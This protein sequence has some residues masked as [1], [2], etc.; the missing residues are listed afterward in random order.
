MSSLNR[1][2]TSCTEVSCM[3]CTEHKQSNTHRNINYAEKCDRLS[4][5][6]VC[7]VI[8]FRA[9]VTSLL[10]NLFLVYAKLGCTNFYNVN[11][12]LKV[13]QKPKKRKI[14][15]LLCSTILSG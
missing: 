14:Y 15:S 2:Q 9:Q 13:T 12:S 5:S 8:T 3:S 7:K 1:K 11:S 4:L 6:P 10:M